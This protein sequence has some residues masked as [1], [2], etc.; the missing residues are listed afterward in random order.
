MADGEIEIEHIATGR[1]VKLLE[2]G[3]SEYADTL[4]ASWNSVDVYGRMD[5]IMTYQGTKRKISVGMKWVFKA[6]TM[7]STFHSQ[8]TKLMTFQYPTY[9]DVDNALAI[10]SPPLVR[11]TF[12]NFMGKDSSTGL[13][14]AMDGVAYTPGLG[15]TPEDSP[16]V[17]Y[18]ANKGRASVSP[19]NLS[20]KLGFTVLHE[21]SLGWHF[22]PGAPEGEEFGFML[23][24]GDMFGPGIIPNIEGGKNWAWNRKTVPLVEVSEPEPPADENSS[25]EEGT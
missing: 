20:L 25:E 21:D 13:L 16:F 22:N 15:F 3:L 23:P 1:K 12:A 4:D 19:T 18:G 8:I 9:A 7:A 2:F 24:A 10:Q 5:P 17:R 11:V 6:S 14:C